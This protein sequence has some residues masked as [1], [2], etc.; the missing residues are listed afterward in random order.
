MTDDAES[1]DAVVQRVEAG[2]FE[3]REPRRE[4]AGV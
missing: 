3:R 1:A 2:A 4:N